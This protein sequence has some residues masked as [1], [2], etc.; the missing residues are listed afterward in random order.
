MTDFELMKLLTMLITLHADAVHTDYRTRLV[1]A[2]EKLVNLRY[3]R[4]SGQV[5]YAALSYHRMQCR[6]LI[7]EGGAAL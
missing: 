4:D 3:Q 1:D 5:V 7:A 2:L 6:G